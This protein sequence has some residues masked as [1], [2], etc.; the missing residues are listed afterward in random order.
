[1]RNHFSCSCGQSVNCADVLSNF[2]RIYLS[3]ASNQYWCPVCWFIQNLGPLPEIGPQFFCRT[4]LH[5]LDPIP[6]IVSPT[7]LGNLTAGSLIGLV[8]LFQTQADTVSATVW[9]LS[10]TAMGLVSA[11]C[12]F[13]RN[14]RLG[15]D[16]QLGAPTTATTL[17]LTT[18]TFTIPPIPRPSGLLCGCNN[19]SR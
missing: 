7:F 16:V 11:E 10:P 3:R 9:G 15:V 17:N 18:A 2:Q 4:C 13:T 12:S 6:D 5:G 8:G 14:V 1:M 19:C